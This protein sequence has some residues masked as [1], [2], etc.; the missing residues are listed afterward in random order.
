MKNKISY[1]KIREILFFIIALLYNFLIGFTSF[2]IFL[3]TS[4]LMFNHKEFIELAIILVFLVLIIPL[5]ILFK[6]KS[7]INI[8]IYI[9]LNIL[10]YIFG[11]LMY[12]IIV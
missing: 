12:V 9:I 5:N 7:K 1:K 6:K 4:W 8:V 11:F 10:S 2:L 3:A